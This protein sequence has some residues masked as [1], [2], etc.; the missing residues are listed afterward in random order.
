MGNDRGVPDISMSAACNG[1]V[2]T[3]QSSAAKPP[4][5]TRSAGPARPLRSSP[6]SWRWP[7]PGGRPFLGVIN[8]ALYPLSARRLPGLV[9]VTSGDNTVSFSQGRAGQTVR[10]FTAQPG[11]D[12]AS[13][14]GTV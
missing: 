1:G 5:G 10:G 12:L 2:D 4:A 13:G 9:D 3:Y 8:P 11:Y 14:L 6:A 7:I